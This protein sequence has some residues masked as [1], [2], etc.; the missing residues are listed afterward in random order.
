[1]LATEQDD[2]TYR[3]R[4]HSYLLS[5]VFLTLPPAVLYE[6]GPKLLDGTIESGELA[7]MCLGTLL[8]LLAAY[9][10]I[11]FASFTFSISDGL[12]R[13]RWS[14][15]VTSKSGEVPLSRIARVRRDALESSES[16]GLQYVY[17]LVVILDD[18]TVIPLT[19]SFSG[20][21]DKQLDQ[22]VAQIRDYLSLFAPMRG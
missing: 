19:R 15:L 22:I 10:Y 1:M 16:S 17:R 9:Y 8:P 2:S 14:N 7:G 3:V 12:F 21:H 11:E 5:M 6:L 13:W 20:T 18:E 4:Y